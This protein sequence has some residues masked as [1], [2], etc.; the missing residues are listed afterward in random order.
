MLEGSSVSPVVSV[1]WYFEAA[2]VCTG[3]WVC[4]LRR[5]DAV[6]EPYTRS[7]FLPWCGFSLSSL[8]AG[9]AAGGR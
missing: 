1:T 9:R 2:A 4:S 3:T 7:A 6:A 8:L 5:A